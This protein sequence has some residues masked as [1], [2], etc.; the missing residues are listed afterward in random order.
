[1]GKA[2]DG[3]RDVA[4]QASALLADDDEAKR[5]VDQLGRYLVE[6]AARNERLLIKLEES[7]KNYAGLLSLRKAVRDYDFVEAAELARVETDVDSEHL[8]RDLRWALQILVDTHEHD[9]S[10]ADRARIIAGRFSLPLGTT[11]EHR[12]SEEEEPTHEGKFY[13][14]IREAMEAAMEDVDDEEE[15]VELEHVMTELEMFTE[16][17]KALGYEVVEVKEPE[18]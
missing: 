18:E 17:M 16:M 5:V 8:L 11:M 13:A 1:M 7:N 2:L 15:T 4:H 3:A 12:I 14:S 10:I 9:S 6:L